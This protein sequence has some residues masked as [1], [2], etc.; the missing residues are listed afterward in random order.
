M[1]KTSD[2]RNQKIGVLNLSVDVIWA[3]S[4]DGFEF[5]QNRM[6]FLTLLTPKFVSKSYNLSGSHFPLSMMKCIMFLS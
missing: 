2:S 1:L 4:G 5:R 3:R 6:H